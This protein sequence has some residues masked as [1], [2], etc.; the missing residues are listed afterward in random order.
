VS[1]KVLVIGATGTVGRSLV[2]ELV[3]ADTRVRAAT[4]DPANAIRR[5]G[6]AK[7]VEVVPFD[8]ERAGTFVGALDDVDRVFL[9]ARPGDDHADRLA[10]PL[11]D[12]MERSG[13]RH[14]VDLS[15]M[16]AESRPSF[17]LRKVEQRL[18]TSSL[19]FT[20]LRPNF[21]MQMFIGGAL[22][23]AVRSRAIRVPA[24]LAK[25]SWIDA[26]DVA[27]VAAAALISERV[28]AGRAY[29]LTGDQALDHAEVAAIIGEASGSDLRYEAITEDEARR[30]LS[31]A[32]FPPPWVER[33]VG[34][35]RLVREGLAAP[36]SPVVREL[37]GRRARTF[38]AFAREHAAMWRL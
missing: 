38:A 6:F 2:A 13:V 21:F 5:G 4:R 1:G 34:F 11:I 26:R 20:H 33:L 25:I 32:G 14:V 37:L 3:R 16:G 19:T 22:L 15:A 18:E 12:V 7:E 23:A 29:T 24:A 30:V 8:L 27:S 9:V 17:A 36:T 28:H 35:Y 10:L 31:R